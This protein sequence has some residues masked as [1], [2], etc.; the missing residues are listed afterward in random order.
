[1]S[2][3]EGL[4]VARVIPYSPD[5]GVARNAI[6]GAP[7]LKDQGITVIILAPWEESLGLNVKPL[8]KS[9]IALSHDNTRNEVIVARTS[10]AKRA[11][12]EIKPD[13]VHVD[14]PAAA[15]GLFIPLVLVSPRRADNKPFS[16]FGATFHSR[17]DSDDGA[18][19]LPRKFQLVKAVS[20]FLPLVGTRWYIPFKYRGTIFGIATSIWDDRLIATSTTVADFW[21]QTIPQEYEIIHNGINTDELTIDGPSISHWLTDGKRIM[22]MSGR[23][24]PRKGFDLGIKAYA[25][26]R[27]QRDDVKLIII[28]EGQMSSS[29]QQLVEIEGIPDVTFYP[30]LPREQYVQALRTAG[31]SGGLFVAASRGGE[32]FNRTI[33]E[34]LSVGTPVVASNLRGHQEAVAHQEFGHMVEPNDVESLT[35]GIVVILDISTETRQHWQNEAHR[36]VRSNFGWET[37]AARQAQTYRRWQAQHGVIPEQAWSGLQRRKSGI[38]ARFRRK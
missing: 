25:E 31:V 7:F 4:T 16:A 10:A 27:K 22:L 5:G 3:Q 28:G 37:I 23:H 24:D 1:M 12:H 32:G 17:I 30:P 18:E 19:H 13:I 2:I 9:L 38:I 34:A 35:R 26:I 8:G 14:E 15:L 29:L 11:L 21:K 6:E 33:P 20:R 36:F